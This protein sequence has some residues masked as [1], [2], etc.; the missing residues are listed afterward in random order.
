MPILASEYNLR[1]SSSS[2]KSIFAEKTL[3]L[4]SHN[5]RM[6]HQNLKKKLGIHIDHVLRA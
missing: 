2:Q 1:Q 3:T 4:I 6:S 5:L